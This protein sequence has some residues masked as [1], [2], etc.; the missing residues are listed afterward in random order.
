MSKVPGADFTDAEFE[1]ELEAR[2]RESM[3]RCAVVGAEFLRGGHQAAYRVARNYLRNEP[4]S[5]TMKQHRLA[6]KIASAA[7]LAGADPD[8]FFSR[9]FV[10]DFLSAGH[11][12]W[13]RNHLIENSSR[14]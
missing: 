6:L 1:L 3:E 5:D 12:A 2:D 11:P 9:P 7:R 4:A 13:Y 8:R 14:A 10:A